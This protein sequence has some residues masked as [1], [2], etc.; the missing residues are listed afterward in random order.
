[1]KSTN[2]RS[3]SEFLSLAFSGW[4][5]SWKGLVENRLG[6]WWL[7]A[8]LILIAAHLSPPWN[9]FISF[10]FIWPK[11]FVI[12]GGCLLL[13]G[14]SLTAKAFFDLG[15]SLS[16]FPEPKSGAA[17]KTKGAYQ[18]CRHPLYQAILIS[19]IGLALCLGS[20]SHFL[21]FISLSLLLRGKAKNEERRLKLVHKEYSEYIKLTYAIIPNFPFLDWN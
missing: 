6:E 21:L 1:M 14:F 2:R 18:K 20:F 7:I 13:V 12:L 3:A 8:Q 19:S 10:D 15:I 9:P 16:P 11:A 5:F 4:G 17:L